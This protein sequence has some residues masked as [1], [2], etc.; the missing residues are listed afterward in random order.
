MARIRLTAKRRPSLVGELW[1]C[2]TVNRT[3]QLERSRTIYI[4]QSDH[5]ATMPAVVLRTITSL[6]IEEE[7]V[8]VL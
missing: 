6:L 8:P 4:L 2:D 1:S 3:S 7:V 5:V